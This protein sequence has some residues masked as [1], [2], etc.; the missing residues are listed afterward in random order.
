MTPGTWFAQGHP[1]LWPSDPQAEARLHEE[2]ERAAQYL[3]A[4]TASKLIH[5]VEGELV[6][7]HSKTLVEVGAAPSAA[8][9]STPEARG[10]LTPG[11][12]WKP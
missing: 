12:R 10:R 1:L 7:E 3:D 9:C 11:R 2:T 5:V 8:R 4:S 6:T